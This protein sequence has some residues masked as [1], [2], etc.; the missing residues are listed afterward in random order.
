MLKKSSFLLA[1]FMLVN[2]LF[3]S[4]TP[5]QVT[6]E[7]KSIPPK[8]YLK[9]VSCMKQSTIRI[10]G[11]K[12]IYF[13][14]YAFEGNPKDGDIVFITH[15][16]G[17]HFSTNEIK[18]VLK[19]GGTLVITADG[20]VQAKEAGFKHI[21][22]VVPGKKYKVN[23]INFQTIASYNINKTF[24]KKDSQWVGYNVTMNSK[25]YYNAGDTDLIP[26]LKKVKADVVFLP[27]GGTYTMDAKEAAKAAN[28]L[29][30]KVAV[31]IHYG[32][33]VGSEEDAKS[34]INLIDTSIQGV[35]LKK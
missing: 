4:I 34:F 20:V 1:F 5:T 29:K 18:K 2:I 14:P 26:E 8:E 25:K 9:G 31:P 21:V 19:K 33:V 10:E 3:S 27:V 13:D 15:T 30:P 35:I 23:G 11:K 22:T 12:T 6:A 24:H 16:H 17:D 28:M 32:D 7:A